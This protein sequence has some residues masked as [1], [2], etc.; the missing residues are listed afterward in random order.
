[1]TD[2][3]MSLQ[4][5]LAKSA[6]RTPRAPHDTQPDRREGPRQLA[7]PPSPPNPTALDGTGS[8]KPPPWRRRSDTR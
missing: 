6:G 5:L 8:P 7:W 2:E 4:D 3:M 1:M